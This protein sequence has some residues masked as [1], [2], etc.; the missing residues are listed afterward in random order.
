MSKAMKPFPQS[1]LNPSSGH[2]VAKAKGKAKMTVENK[3][4]M[5]EPENSG[6]IPMCCMSFFW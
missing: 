1:K 4:N 2:G 3:F 5:A 6:K